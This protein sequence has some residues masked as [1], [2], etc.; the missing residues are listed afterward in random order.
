MV[1]LALHLVG[2]DVGDLCKLGRHVTESPS[3]VQKSSCAVGVHLRT[4]QRWVKEGLIEPDVVT[5]SG[6]MRWNIDRLL[7]QI[8]DLPR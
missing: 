8:Q 6:H 5:P 3:R 7:E 2:Q 1:P 4:L